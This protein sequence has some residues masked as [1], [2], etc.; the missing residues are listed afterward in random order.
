MKR[1]H[2][3]RVLF[4]GDAAHAMSPH[5]GQG[6]N[7]ALLDACTFAACSNRRAISASRFRTIRRLRRAHVRFYGSLTLALT[8]FFQSNG[9]IK[10]IGRDVALPIMT[11]LP[12]VRGQMILSMSGLKGGLREGG[13]T[14]L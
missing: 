7:L 4:L 5:L 12:W 9:M 6:I 2:T 10:G 3:D 1:W 13:I 14:I 11:H 8:P